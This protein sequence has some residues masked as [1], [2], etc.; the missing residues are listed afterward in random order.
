MPIYDFRCDSCGHAFSLRF[1]SVTD[2]ERV[3]IVCPACGSAHARRVIKRVAIAR[4]GRD[5]RKL[6]SKEMLSV[7]ESGDRNQVETMFSQVT[8]SKDGLPAKDQQSD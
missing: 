1:K 4:A 6:S 3:D 5:Y 7:L 2:Y 8:G